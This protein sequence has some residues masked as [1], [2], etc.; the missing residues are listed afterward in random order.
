MHE[1]S[2]A[3]WDGN[4]LNRGY[5]HNQVEYTNRS[6][7]CIQLKGKSSQQD[8]KVELLSGICFMSKNGENFHRFSGNCQILHL[9]LLPGHANEA[10]DEQGLGFCR[11]EAMLLEDIGGTMCVYP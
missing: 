2:P 11:F 5:H 3:N 9:W 4:A 10:T 8:A 1:L 7:E 6:L